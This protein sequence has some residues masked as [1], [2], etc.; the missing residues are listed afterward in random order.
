MNERIPSPRLLRTPYEVDD[1]AATLV[2]PRRVPL[3]SFG[4]EQFAA[5]MQAELEALRAARDASAA[6]AARAVRIRARRPNV[7][8]VPRAPHDPPPPW[9]VAK[10]IPTERADVLLPVPR[11]HAPAPAAAPPPRKRSA[12]R[13]LVL[14]AFV[15]GALGA[16]HHR[17]ARVQAASEL[18]SLAERIAPPA[19]K[20]GPS[21][22]GLGPA[23][24]R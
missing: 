15:A 14:V 18:R 20:A 6:R 22:G 24:G 23:A 10:T 16:W 9:E 13:W 21:A 1:Q 8:Q 19:A 4:R 17:Q 12:L 3:P 11:A 7:F 5:M 2:R